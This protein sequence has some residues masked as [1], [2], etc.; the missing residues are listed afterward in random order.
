MVYD[1][2]LMFLAWLLATVAGVLIVLYGPN[3]SA[4]VAVGRAVL[5]ALPGGAEPDVVAAVGAVLSRARS[6]LLGRLIGA[7]S[8]AD[9]DELARFG[10][11]SEPLSDLVQDV[12]REL[13]ERRMR[14]G[15]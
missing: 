10:A 9:W 5:W 13:A 11:G 15:R 1:P 3:R 4:E 8:P 14:R 6:G 7:L 2:P 12:L